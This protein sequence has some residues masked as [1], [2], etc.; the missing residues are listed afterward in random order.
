L[1][2]KAA[3][4]TSLESSWDKRRSMFRATFVVGAGT[5]SKVES[6]AVAAARKKGHGRASS[7]LATTGPSY[8]QAPK[9]NLN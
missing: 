4:R 5:K 1:R 9:S 2:G 3:K 7:V 8:V 6:K